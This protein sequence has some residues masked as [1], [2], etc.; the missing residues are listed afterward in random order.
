MPQR[1]L[2]FAKHEGELSHLLSGDAEMYVLS[3]TRLSKMNDNVPH[4][5]TFNHNRYVN[6]LWS[7]L[8][9]YEYEFSSRRKME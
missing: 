2:L 6:R 5:L 7:T 4:L 3:T 8:V 9:L 1:T